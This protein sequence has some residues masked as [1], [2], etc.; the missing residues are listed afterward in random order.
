M[1]EEFLLGNGAMALGLLEAGCQIMTSYPGTP[2]SEILPEMVRF[3]KA[4]NLNTGI[5]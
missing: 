4:A 3:S 1:K 2:S 5:E